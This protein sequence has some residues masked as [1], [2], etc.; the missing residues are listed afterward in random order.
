MCNVFCCAKQKG[1]N[2]REEGDGIRQILLAALKDEL[3][4]REFLAYCRRVY[5]GLWRPA[6][7]HIFVAKALDRV[8]DG[9]CRRLMVFIPP[10]HGKSMQITEC[11][12]SYFLGRFPDKRV[13]VLSYSAELAA[14]FGRQNRQKIAEFGKL[15]GISLSRS[16]AG[17]NAFSI[18]DRRGGLLS[19]GLGGSITGQGADLLIIDDPVKNRE[20]AE[21]SIIRDKVF[22]EYQSTA[23]TRLQAGA[24]V[25][26]VMTRWHEDDLCGRLLAQLDGEWEVIRLPALA[27]A[28]DPLNRSVG[29]ALW[30]EMGFGKDWAEE[31]RKA[32]GSYAFAALYQ[33]RPAPAG[34]GLIKREWWRFYQDKPEMVA[35]VLSVDAAFK[36]GEDASNVSIQAWGKRGATLYFLGDDTRP[37]DFPETIRALRAMHEKYKPRCVYVED[38]AN[39]PAIISMLHSEITGLIPVNPQGGKVARAHAVSAAIESGNVLLPRTPQAYALM[40]ECAAFPNGLRDD[41]VDAMTQALNQLLYHG[42]SVDAHKTAVRW[43][44]D[45]WEDYYGASEESKKALIEKWGDPF[46]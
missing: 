5:G 14:R 39:G 9:S 37:M 38:K 7:H 42:A 29:E 21:S 15:F 43:H 30:P 35:V 2:K 3:C 18:A 40:D 24:A 32:V 12:P 11:L 22:A 19:V 6:R 13:M 33:Q 34:G 44:K 27:E 31:T 1:Q 36:G 26:I 16:H 46:G 4:R 45:Q 23:Y 41:R 20:E 8:L 28:V 25:I 17:A 10:R